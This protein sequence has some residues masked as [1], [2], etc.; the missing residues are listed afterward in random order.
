MKFFLENVCFKQCL[1]FIVTLSSE[2]R[3]GYSMLLAYYS[4]DY[5]YCC[6]FSTRCYAEPGYEITCRLSVCLSVTLRYRDHIHIGWNTSKMILRPNNLRS[7]RTPQHGKSGA[8]GIPTKLGWNGLC[9]C[10]IIPCVLLT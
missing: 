4:T 1:M 10:E 2:L 5:C 6:A 3:Y 8:T 7:M 9:L